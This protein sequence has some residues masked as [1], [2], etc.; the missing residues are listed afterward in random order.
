MVLGAFI[1]GYPAV[2]YRRAVPRPPLKI[3][4]LD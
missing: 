2:K 1:L 3:K 4:G